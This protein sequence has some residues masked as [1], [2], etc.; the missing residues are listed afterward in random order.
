L[1]LQN[2][3]LRSLE[4]YDID[5]RKFVRP[6]SFDPTQAP[7]REIEEH[8]LDASTKGINDWISL[9]LHPYPQNLLTRWFWRFPAITPNV[10]TTFN[11]SVSFLA[12]VPLAFGYFLWPILW[13]NV[14]GILDGVDG[15]LA[16][17]TLRY[18]KFGDQLDHI[19]DQVYEPLWYLAIGWAL[20]SRV[21]WIVSPVQIS[22][23]FLF[24]YFLDRIAAGWFRARKGVQIHDYRRIDRTIRLFGARRNTVLFLLLIGVCAEAFPAAFAVSAIYMAL[25]AAARM[26]RF[27]W[28]E[29]KGLK[30]EIPGEG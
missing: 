7:T 28:I 2:L 18:S 5:L 14:Q 15:K 17:T 27:V 11:V 25:T 23:L 9:Y 19:S 22:W 16:R 8:L 20:Q 4:R 1:D 26:G 29:A 10:L 6:Q 21:S 30:P 3:N 12:I 24:F 13:G